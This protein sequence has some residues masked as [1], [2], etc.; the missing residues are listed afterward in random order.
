MKN[1]ERCFFTAKRPKLA[2]QAKVKNLRE[3]VNAKRGRRTKIAR[4]LGVTSND[5]YYS[6]SGDMGVSV[7]KYRLIKKAALEVQAEEQNPQ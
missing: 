1:V 6:L 5:I 3:W 4:K 7:E 2:S